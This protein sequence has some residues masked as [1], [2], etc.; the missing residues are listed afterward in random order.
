MR[1]I[2]AIM[3]FVLLSCGDG[4]PPFDLPY[5]ECVI[6]ENCPRSMPRCISLPFTASAG[7]V[8]VRQCTFDCTERPLSCPNVDLGAGHQVLSACWPFGPSEQGPIGNYCV[9]A[10]DTAVDPEI[11]CELSGNTPTEVA[12]SDGS[13]RCLCLPTGS[14]SDGG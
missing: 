13:S 5:Q 14:N 9:Q 4:S 8:T 10:C 1:S 2:L 7:T 11:M 6:D 3:A 12:L